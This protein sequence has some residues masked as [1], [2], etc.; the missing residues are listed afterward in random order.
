[1]RSDHAVALLH[2]TE[3]FQGVAEETVGLVAERSSERHY[4]KGQLIFH[5]GDDGD[6]LFILAEGSVKVFVTSED[7]DEMVLATM[8]PPETFGELS[9]IDGRPRSASAETLEPSRALVLARRSFLDLLHGNAAVTDALMKGLGTMVRRLT[10]QAS[11]LVFLDLHG[12]LAK[13]L[14][15][16]APEGGAVVE[17]GMTQTDLAAMVG[18]TRQTVNQI[19]HSFEQR[20]YIRLDGRRVELLKP[21]MLKRRAGL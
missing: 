15:A 20:G 3:L 10:V 5:E 7:G 1:M 8:R 16:L 13:T 2:A 4:K 9:L 18:G 14:L 19:L 21:E 6:S 12:R 11:D 17:L